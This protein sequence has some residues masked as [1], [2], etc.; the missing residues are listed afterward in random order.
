METETFTPDTADVLAAGRE[1]PVRD[2]LRPLDQLAAREHLQ[3]IRSWWLDAAEGYL[4]LADKGCR[5]SLHD[6]Q[7]ALRASKHYGPASKAVA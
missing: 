2:A 5:D 1:Y 7:R 4:S 3:A 6:A